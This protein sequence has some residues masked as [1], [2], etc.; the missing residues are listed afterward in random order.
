MICVYHIYTLSKVIGRKPAVCSLEK[1]SIYL[2]GEELS[3]KPLKHTQI[4]FGSARNTKCPLTSAAGV[5]GSD[6]RKGSGLQV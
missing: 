2:H 3:Y 5:S 6:R 4:N 1:L